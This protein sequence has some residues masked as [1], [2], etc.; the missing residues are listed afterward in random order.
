MTQKSLDNY[1]DEALDKITEWINYHVWLI[2][3]WWHAGKYGPPTLW[4]NI[5]TYFD[6]PPP[7]STADPDDGVVSFA[8]KHM[9]K[10]QIHREA[11]YHYLKTKWIVRPESMVYALNRMKTKKDKKY[12]SM[13]LELEKLVLEN[14]SALL[15]EVE[16]RRVHTDEE[17]TLATTDPVVKAHIRQT[18][19]TYIESLEFINSLPISFQIAWP[20]KVARSK[21]LENK[22]LKHL[23]LN[24]A[25]TSTEKIEYVLGIIE[26][27]DYCIFK[28]GDNVRNYVQFCREGSD[29]VLNFPYS[30]KYGHRHLQVDRVGL[31]LKSHGF[32]SIIA[33]WPQFIKQEIFM[34]AR[35]S[36]SKSGFVQLEAYFG[37]DHEHFATE[38]TME[39]AKKIFQ[40]KDEVSVDIAIGSWR[41]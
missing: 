30:I 7:A 21:M 28:F 39:I 37:R 17:L 13:L 20:E 19:D 40:F 18:Y 12:M 33:L 11:W 38:I 23:S 24:P 3:D 31:I 26:S 5:Q 2:E 41:K 1:F 34:L 25:L 16:I 14:Y 15:A 22:V 27:Y 10:K 6:P 35:D 32:G 29:L 36:C 8:L 9:T 4:Y